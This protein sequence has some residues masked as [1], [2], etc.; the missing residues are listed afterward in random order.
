MVC[1]CHFK[2]LCYCKIFCINRRNS[3]FSLCYRDSIHTIVGN[4]HILAMCVINCSSVDA[5]DYCM[6]VQFQITLVTE[7]LSHSSQELI[8][9]FLCY[10]HSIHMIVGSIHILAMC[11]INCS[12]MDAPNY[13]MSMQ[14]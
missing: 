1:Q 11:V 3:Y 7:D 10:R 8:Y 6:S 13:C 9:F 14:F 2:L 5:L 4:I 12:D